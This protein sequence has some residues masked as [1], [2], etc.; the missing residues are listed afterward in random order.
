MEVPE[1]GGTP[2][3]RTKASEAEYHQQP[4]FLP[5]GRSLLFDILRSGQPGQIAYLPAGATDHVVLLDGTDPRYVSSGHLLFTREAAVWAVGFDVVSGRMT[6]DPVPVLEG[7]SITGSGVARSAVA[8]DG[9][10]AYLAGNSRGLRMI[11]R[12]DRQGHE[13]ALPGLPPNRYEVVRV[14]PD[15]TRLAYD[16]GGRQSDIWTYDFA[17][18]T[19]VR[20]TADASVDRSPVWTPDGSRLIFLSDRGGRPSLY[21]QNA[22]GTGAAERLLPE[23]SR[24]VTHADG[25]SNDGKRLLVGFVRPGESQ[26]IGMIDMVGE[27]RVQDL[28]TM[29]SVAAGS[30]VSPDGRWVA[31]HSDLSGTQEIYVERFP[32]LG[33]RQ[34]ISTS[35]GT[36]PR[37][38]PGGRELFYK[39]GN[40][41]GVF[42][43]SISSGPK[44]AAGTP[45]LL[46][47]GPFLTAGPTTRPFDVTPDGQ[48]ILIKSEDM[49]ANPAPTLVVVQNWLEELK[50]LVPGAGQPPAR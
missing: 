33:D 22:D 47:E 39:S 43:V 1:S 48:F 9:T 11:V 31:Y 40:G 15:G 28:I 20:V 7:V 25:W 49:P 23:G 8:A 32:E 35:G 12:V 44:L 30:A 29:P 46:F 19:A 50:R 24:T 4:H 37:W 18:N 34:K 16:M 6:G 13:A 21:V 14:S 17:R 45:R 36:S 10:L 2:K 41:R 3:P 38:A 27:L 5:D 26:N 42:S